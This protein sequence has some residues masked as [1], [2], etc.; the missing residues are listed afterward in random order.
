MIVAVHISL[1]CLYACIEIPALAKPMGDMI[2]H[3][4]W[5]NRIIS[6]RFIRQSQI[7][8]GNVQPNDLKN[9]LQ[10]ISDVL[11]MEDPLQSY[12]V[13]LVVDG[14]KEQKIK[15]VLNIVKN[16][17]I[18]DPRRSYQCIKILV[19][20]SQKCSLV[21]AYLLQNPSRWQ[22]A[23]DWLKK[24]IN[25]YYW[26]AQPHVTNESHVSKSFQ[27]TVSAQYTLAEA[28]ALL[29]ETEKQSSDQPSTSISTNSG[30]Q[31]K[32]FEEPEEDWDKEID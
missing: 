1:Q 10:I 31:S 30:I 32:F 12:R 26:T 4:C 6:E 23:V 7:L 17:Y 19:S 29:F 22:W 16:S 15:G 20:L 25:E 8:L 14:S 27:R 11:C 3:C 24:K 18:S 2:L 21:K 5:C 13:N 28:T 9:V